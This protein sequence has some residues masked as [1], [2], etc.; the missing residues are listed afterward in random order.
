[1][2]NP[3]LQATPIL[4]FHHPDI[5]AL[6]DDRGWKQLPEYERI[7]AVYH[8]VKDEIVFGYNRLDNIKASEVLKDGY[9]QCNTKSTLFMALLRAVGIMCRFHG[10]TIDKTLQK[11]A[12]PLWA[13]LMAPQSIIHSWAEVYYQDKWIE[14]EGFILDESYLSSIQQKFAGNSGGFCGYGIA[15]ECLS[16]PSVQWQGK[17]TYIQKQGINQD[18]GVYDNPDEFYQ[19]HGTNLSGVKRWLYQNLLR[20]LINRNVEQLRR[21]SYSQV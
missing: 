17:N 21:I 1:M 14:L 10:F 3:L 11:G 15:T 13:H 6:I 2:T 20:H 18:F 5:T 4:D 19:K 8:F 16:S 9:G 7:G 12:L